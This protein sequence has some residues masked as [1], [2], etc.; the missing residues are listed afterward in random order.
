[1]MNTELKTFLEAS[2]LPSLWYIAS[3]YS[4]P[5]P[6]VRAGR[7]SAVR[8]CVVDMIKEFPAV[9]PFS[10]VLYSSD[11]QADI[12]TPPEGWY[13]FGLGFLRKADKLILLKLEGWQQS[14]GMAIEIAFAKAQGIE[15]ESYTLNGILSG[16]EVPF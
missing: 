6:E 15:I 16:E 5:C 7:V 4:H 8:Q 9:V 13:R 10:P 11:L 14:V 2:T 3:P 12:E 1:M